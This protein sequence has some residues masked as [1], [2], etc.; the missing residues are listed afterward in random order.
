MPGPGTVADTYARDVAGIG[1]GLALILQQLW[2][3]VSPTA[4]TTTW[5]PLVD[6]AV[7]AFAAAQAVTAETADPYL[8][9]VLAAQGRQATATRVIDPA[10]FAGTTLDGIGLDTLLRVPAAR[11]ERALTDGAPHREAM[12]AG[13]RRLALYAQTEIADTARASTAAAM[14][15]RRIGG[16]YRRLRLPSC[17]RCVIL[18]GRWYRWSSG[19]RRHPGCDCQHVPAEQDTDTDDQGLLTDPKAAIDAGQVTGLTRAELTALHAGADPAQ[20]INARRG[21][22]VLGQHTYTT[23]GTT[24]R[25]IAGARILARGAARATGSPAGLTYRNL[26][27]T[28]AELARHAQLLRRG[29]TFTRGTATGGAQTYAYRFTRTGRLTVAEISRVARTQEE[30]TRLLINNGY[31]L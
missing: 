15:T 23:T 25:G 9:A 20:V 3:Q 10:G 21:T 4:V 18:A 31:L 13:Q 8:D 6:Q 26:T 30:Y 24:R 7:A 22:Y 29:R 16:Y 12:L 1:R 27:F 11:V 5:S 28:R 19:F 17:P 2:R 14:A